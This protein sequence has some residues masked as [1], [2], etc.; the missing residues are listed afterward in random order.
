MYKHGISKV[1]VAPL[2]DTIFSIPISLFFS[3]IN[4]MERIFKTKF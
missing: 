2:A 4:N 1:L 3:V